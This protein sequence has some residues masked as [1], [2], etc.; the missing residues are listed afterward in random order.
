MV[1]DSLETRHILDVRV[2]PGWVAEV[3]R[4]LPFIHGEAVVAV[5]AYRDS[6][7][8]LVDYEVVI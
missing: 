5:I 4:L 8:A 3:T 2:H 1:R 7:G 6:E